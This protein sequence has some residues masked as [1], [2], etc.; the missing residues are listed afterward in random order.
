MPSHVMFLEGI[1][2]ED[3]PDEEE[4][5]NEIDTPAD[6]ASSTDEEVISSDESAGMPDV[7]EE[8]MEQIS[9][10]DELPEFF[11]TLDDWPKT[12]NLLC[13]C[14]SNRIRGRPWFIPLSFSKIV[15]K[16]GKE[17]MAYRV[18]KCFDNEFCMMRY[19]NRVYD[20]HVNPHNSRDRKWELTRFIHD[21]YFIFTGKKVIKIPEAEDPLIQI[22]Y[23]GPKGITAKEYRERNEAKAVLLDIEAPEY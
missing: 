18:H 19:L 12:V 17:V 16:A 2:P 8:L 5:L 21:I 9:D 11:T 1:L 14:C 10:Y 7:G 13:C 15:N 3:C 6:Y 20:D 22:Q 4:V 23:H